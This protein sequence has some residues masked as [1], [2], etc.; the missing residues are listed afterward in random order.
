M[1]I[2]V[3]AAHPDDEILGIGGTVKRHV[4]S[5]DEAFCVILGEGITSRYDKRKNAG[6]DSLHELRESAYR[7]A[8]IIGYKEIFFEGLPDNRFDGLELL[9]IVKTVEKHIIAIKPDIIYTHHHGDIN[10]DHRITFN[11]VITAARPIGNE[12]PLEIYSFETV[13]STEW[14]YG[15]SEMMFRPNVFIDITSTIEDKIKALE[16]YRSELKQYPHPRSAEG[17]IITSKKW[18]TVISREYAEP[19]EAIRIVR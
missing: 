9:D 13:S 11:A 3:V 2:L 6:V 10:I 12:Y 18:G 16:C 5:G 15:N 4:L 14:N 1:K 7:A 8:S 19:L 17:V